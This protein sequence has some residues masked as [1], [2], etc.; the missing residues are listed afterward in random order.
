MV[1]L[2]E[3]VQ[4]IIESA[5]YPIDDDH[6]MAI[7]QLLKPSIERLIE[8]YQHK[9]IASGV[10]IPKSDLKS[11]FLENLWK[12]ILVCQNEP[13]LS[14]KR[15]F[16]HR[17]KLRDAD[18]YHQN[19]STASFISLDTNSQQTSSTDPLI[20]KLRDHSKPINQMALKL[21]LADFNKQY[22]KEGSLIRLLIASWSPA[23]VA[24]I[25][26]H[27]SNYSALSR[28]KICRLRHLF[29]QFYNQYQ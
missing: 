7:Y 5:N 4:A 18:L 16:F 1:S 6:F 17:I 19:K 13:N 21:I 29:R 9:A 15:V 10:I 12:S 23:E 2:W 8:H 24:R 26:Y 3:T 14:F 22:P 20:N 11:I 25:A 27:D 28:Q